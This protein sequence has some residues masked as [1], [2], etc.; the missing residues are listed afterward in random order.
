MSDDAQAF[1][2]VLGANEQ[3]AKTFTLGHLDAVAARGLAIVTCF[4]SRIEPLQMLGLAPGDA[5]IIRVAGGRVTNEVLRSLELA[6][7]RLGVERVAVIQHTECAAP[8][9]DDG[10]LATDL[11]RIRSSAV[12]ADD[13]PLI[14]LRYD[15]RTGLLEQPLD[16]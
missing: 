1:A 2:D 14:G 13:I 11:E 8:N 9:V 10:S 12:I 5:K 7:T 4:D 6:T 15:V 3:Y 16:D